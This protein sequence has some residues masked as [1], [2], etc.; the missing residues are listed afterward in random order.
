MG[1]VKF[2]D[3]RTAALRAR[4]RQTRQYQVAAVAPAGGALF[5]LVKAPRYS[6]DLGLLPIL[7]GAAFLLGVAV[8]FS[9]VNWRCPACRRHLG[10]RWNPHHCMA[11]GFILRPR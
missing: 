5:L 10:P 11:C 6:V 4:F 9:W 7:L 1:T 2:G 3:N 8:V